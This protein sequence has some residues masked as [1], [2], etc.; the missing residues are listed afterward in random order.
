MA[1]KLLIILILLIILGSLGSALYFMVTDKGGGK[2]MVKALS[3]RIGLSLSLF[4]LLFILYFLGI[5]RP[6]GLLPSAPPAPA[7]APK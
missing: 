4:L 1:A 6:H 2:R 3:W 5:V 7:A